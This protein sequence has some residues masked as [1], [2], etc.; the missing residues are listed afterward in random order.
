MNVGRQKRVTRRTV[1]PWGIRR[2]GA[3][4]REDVGS[5]RKSGCG[6]P[7][8]WVRPEE[9][10]SMSIPVAEGQKLDPHTPP[11]PPKKKGKKKEKDLG[12]HMDGR[13]RSAVSKARTM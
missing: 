8:D 3:A 5:V 1:P 13:I 9:A 10:K 7:R 11:Q 6:T 12:Q 2:R 4:S